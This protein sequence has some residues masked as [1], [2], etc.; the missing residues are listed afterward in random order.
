MPDPLTMRGYDAVVPGSAKTIIDN[1]TADAQHVRD[2]ERRSLEQD[3]W[4][5]KASRLTAIVVPVSGVALA[6][7]A[8]WLLNS[9]GAFVG[10][11]VAALGGPLMAAILKRSE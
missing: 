3:A 8:G 1:F 11:S 6:V 7:F 10:G 9:P 5:G 4:E 2:M